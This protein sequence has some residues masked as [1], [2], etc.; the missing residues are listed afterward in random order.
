MLNTGESDNSLPYHYNKRGFRADFSWKIGDHKIQIGAEDYRIHTD[1]LTEYGS[2]GIYY[3]SAYSIPTAT[4]DGANP[5]VIIPANTPYVM[6]YNAKNGGKLFQTNRGAYI[7]DYWQA[8]KNVLIYGGLRRDNAKASLADGQHGLDLYTTSPRLGVSWDVHGDSSMKIGLSAG[9]YSLPVPGVVMDSLFNN[10]AYNYTYSTYTGINADGSP[11]G[12]KQFASHT[13]ASSAANAREL[14][15]AH[16]KNSLQDNFTLYMQDNSLIPDWSETVELD[17]SK[18][19][20]ALAVWSDLDSGSGI[21]SSAY[22]Y[23]QSLGYADPYIKN[24]VLINPGSAV[25]LTN[26]FNHDGKLATV[27]IPGSNTGL[28]KAKRN[29]YT[30]TLDMVHPETPEQPFF[31]DFSYSW[32][33]VHGNYEGYYGETNGNVLG[34]PTLRYAGLSE[35]SSGDLPG[36]V[37]NTVRINFSHTFAHSITAGI[38]GYWQSGNPRSCYTTYPESTNAAAQ[39][40]ESSFYCNGVLTPRGSLGHMPSYWDLDLHMGWTHKVGLNTFSVQFG[41]NNILNRQMLIYRDPFEG[42]YSNGSF[43]TETRYDGRV[44]TAARSAWLSLRYSFN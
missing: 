26:D 16:L 35:G 13:V 21:T 18:I 31:L 41:V 36:D 3:Y 4:N 17:Y 30:M 20:R 12:A 43:I 5:S 44:Y 29:A 37:R 32:K 24:Y 22:R 15:S 8:S 33:H 2:K 28:P 7:E 39:G 10:Y 9:E 1:A 42:Y 27:T 23:L 40:G 25:T 34:S 19:K 14:T 11:I 38:G 6:N